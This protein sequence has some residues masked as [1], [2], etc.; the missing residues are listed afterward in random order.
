MPLMLY[1]YILKDLMRVILLTTVVL[2]TVIAFGA[3]IRPLADDQFLGPLQI[4]KYIMLAI[5]PP[6]AAPLKPLTPS[7][8]SAA[9]TP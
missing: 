9:M 6:L 1:R 5:V 2:V 3:A 8:I 4:I 7:F